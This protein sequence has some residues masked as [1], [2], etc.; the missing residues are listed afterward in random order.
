[1]NERPPIL[2]RIDE[3]T[4]RYGPG[5]TQVCRHCIEQHKKDAE[6][7]IV[8]DLKKRSFPSSIVNVVDEWKTIRDLLKLLEAQH[9]E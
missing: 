6:H 8:E 5:D 4:P 1:M 9:G 3:Q 2:D 7:R